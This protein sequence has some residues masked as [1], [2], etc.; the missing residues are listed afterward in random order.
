MNRDSH[1]GVD[2]L[3]AHLEPA[4]AELVRAAG[5]RF[6][7]PDPDPGFVLELR[8]RLTRA[9]DGV[10]DLGGVAMDGGRAWWPVRVFVALAAYVFRHLAP[11]P[12]R[13]LLPLAV[14][15]VLV[16]AGAGATVFGWWPG[17]STTA[18]AREILARAEAVASGADAQAVRSYVMTQ[19][20]WYNDF[21]HT[22]SRRWYA[23]PERWRIETETP[24]MDADGD[25]KDVRRTV[26]VRNGET[27]W[28]YLEDEGV[29]EIH[30][31]A[32][33]WYW[34]FFTAPG[35]PQLGEPAGGDLEAFLA[36]AK[37]CYKPRLTGDD[38]VAGR[39][40]YVIELG[41]SSCVRRFSSVSRSTDWPIT[42][43][44]DQETYFILKAVASD[45]H[46]MA[47]HEVT[48]VEYDVPIDPARFTFTPPP[49]AELRNLRGTPPPS[50]PGPFAE[51]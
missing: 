10:D 13:R 24:D 15:S 42:L 39:Q 7:A 19:E 41:R 31:A 1:P 33:R 23:G 50:G 43:W 37:D 16:L 47:T 22:V 8:A 12:G 51:P 11:P 44:I 25:V 14:T 2:L 29:V 32:A 3:D 18:S 46:S 28:N 34:H 35:L 30:D 45:G 38:T 21:P 9:M 48:A 6:R 27:L 36:Q 49:G 20:S 17:H 4:D 40:T 5:R 26:V